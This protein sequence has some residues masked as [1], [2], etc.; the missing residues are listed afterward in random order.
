MFYGQY[1]DSGSGMAIVGHEHIFAHDAWRAGFYAGHFSLNL[2][3]TGRIGMQLPK[4]AQYSSYSNFVY[5]EVRK[6]IVENLY[7]GVQ[8]LWSGGDAKLNDKTDPAI[9][10]AFEDHMSGSNHALGLLMTY[11]T[12]DNMMGATEGLNVDL[13]TLHYSKDKKTGKSFDRFDAEV[14]QYFPIGDDV[15]AYRVI[16][17]EMVGETPEYEFVTPNLRGADWNKYRGSSLYQ[18]G[19]VWRL[20]VQQ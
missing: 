20:Q 14:S 11:D 17:K 10:K 9:K 3:Y 1:T 4:A 15:L 19:V 2:K 13:S 16:G 6:Q 5:G 12:R 8:G 18:A 7:F